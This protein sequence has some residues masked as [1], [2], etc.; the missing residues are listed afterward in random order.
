VEQTVEIDGTRYCEG[1]LVDTVNFERLLQDHHRPQ[2]DS[3]LDEI[4]ISRI[5]DAKQIRAPNNLHDAFANLC[6]LFAATVGEDDVKLFEYHVR[7]DASKPNAFN[8]TIV[9]IRVDSKIT[10]DW[11]HENLDVGMRQG[12]LAAD[13]ACKK[14]MAHRHDPLTPALVPD[15]SG[16]GVR[17]IR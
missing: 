12:Y 1:A 13:E 16:A 14:Y 7:E 17:I 11:S 6:Q 5:I 2:E 4:W 9:E 8:G 3:S 10:F 15:R